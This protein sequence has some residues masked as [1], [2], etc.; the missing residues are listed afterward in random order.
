MKGL[1]R[2]K[3]T[4]I[5]SGS[6]AP[7]ETQ[8]ISRRIIMRSERGIM[9]EVVAVVVAAPCVRTYL[10]AAAAAGIGASTALSPPSI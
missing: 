8:L 7:A 5:S 2:V 1:C 4:V 10:A 9:V 6:E 3:N